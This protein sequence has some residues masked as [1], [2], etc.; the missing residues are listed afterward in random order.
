MTFRKCRQRVESDQ[1]HQPGHFKPPPLVKPYQRP[2][3]ILSASKPKN[4]RKSNLTLRSTFIF[5]PTTFKIKIPGGVSITQ[6][7]DVTDLAIL[8]KNNQP[9]VQSPANITTIAFKGIEFP[10]IVPNLPK[11][12]QFYPTVSVICFTECNICTLAQLAQLNVVRRIQQFVIVNNPVTSLTYW[13]PYLAWKT[14]INSVNGE[15]VIF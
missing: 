2:R 15:T 14:G 7:L 4:E 8:F 3:Q 12:K 9:G 11:L 1:T 5:R 6:Q 10:H 13:R